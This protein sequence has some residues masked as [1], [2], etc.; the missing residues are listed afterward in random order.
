M[1]WAYI[2][3][4]WWVIAFVL[5]CAI[6]YERGLQERHQ[7]YVQLTAQ[8]A[9]LAQEKAAAEDIQQNLQRQINS[10]SDLAWME[11][12]LM[13]GLGLVVEGQQKIYFYDQND[14]ERF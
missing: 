13:K 3:D 14:A 12:T 1:K 2:L 4:S 9:V 11:L 5:G 8:A 6:L 7:L 10:Q